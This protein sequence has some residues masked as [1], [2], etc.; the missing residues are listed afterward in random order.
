MKKLLDDM[1]FYFENYESIKKILKYGMEPGDPA[2]MGDA[3]WLYDNDIISKREYLALEDGDNFEVYEKV[4]DGLGES[5]RKMCSGCI[6]CTFNSNC[7]GLG[8]PCSTRRLTSKNRVTLNADL[9]CKLNKSNKFFEEEEEVE[10][11]KICVGA[12]AKKLGISEKEFINRL[13]D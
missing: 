3:E 5:I 13:T 10:V 7:K 6:A 9:W 8:A 11:P 12:M 1:D 4:M 2:N